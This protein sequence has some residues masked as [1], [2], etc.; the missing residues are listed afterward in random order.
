MLGRC[1]RASLLSVALLWPV[2]VWAQSPAHKL[3]RGLLNTFLG[4]T[5]LLR[6]PQYL[7]HC[8]SEDYYRRDLNVIAGCPV[9]ALVQPLGRELLGVAETLT[10]S[11][12]V[13]PAPFYGSPYSR[14]LAG[15]SPWGARLPASDIRP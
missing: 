13:W 9:R 11:A 2:P 4:W 3:R 14:F 7:W 8:V 6:V 1:V 10:F 5:E 12:A 15:D